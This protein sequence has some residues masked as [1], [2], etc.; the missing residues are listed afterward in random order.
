MEREIE[1]F[2]HLMSQAGAKF[3]VLPRRTPDGNHYLKIHE[4]LKDSLERFGYSIYT[5]PN[6]QRGRLGDELS[7]PVIVVA[8]NFD[9]LTQLRTTIN[10][11][12]LEH[13]V[14][15]IAY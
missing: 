13:R 6:A 11:F 3:G 9:E 10:G 5:T 1:D 2:I 8:A 15:Y 12:K 7:V 14:L 4:N